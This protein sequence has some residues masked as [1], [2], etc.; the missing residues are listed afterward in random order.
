MSLLK[1]SEQGA[2][3]LEVDT[4]LGTCPLPGWLQKAACRMLSKCFTIPWTL[5]AGKKLG[6]SRILTLSGP[7]QQLGPSQELVQERRCAR[8]RRLYDS[9]TAMEGPDPHLELG[10]GCSGISM[11][12]QIVAPNG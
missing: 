1:P 9:C 10:A 2:P 3:Y 5:V 4:P 12:V 6:A 11:A 7:G 8:P